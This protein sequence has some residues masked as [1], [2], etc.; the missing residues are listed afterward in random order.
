MPGKCSLTFEPLRENPGNNI[1]KEVF[2]MYNT[3][4]NNDEHRAYF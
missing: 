1:P 2:D 3:I 4:S